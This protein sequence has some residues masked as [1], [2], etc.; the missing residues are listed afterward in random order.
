MTKEIAALDRIRAQG[1][2]RQRTI[3]SRKND[4]GLIKKEYW[5]D[6]EQHTKLKKLLSELINNALLPLNPRD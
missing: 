1:A 5:A 3:R 4:G 6:Q 2:A